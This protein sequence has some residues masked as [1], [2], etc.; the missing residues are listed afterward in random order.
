MLKKRIY[1]S[2]LSVALFLHFGIAV[3]AETVKVK[4]LKNEGDFVLILPSGYV[5]QGAPVF[6]CKINGQIEPC[7]VLRK[8]EQVQPK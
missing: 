3:A 1:S 6:P 8:G 2:F 5:I 4:V 7:Y